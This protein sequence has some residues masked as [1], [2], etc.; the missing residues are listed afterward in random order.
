MDPPALDKNGGMTKFSARSGAIIFAPP[1]QVSSLAESEDSYGVG[2][3]TFKRANTS[4]KT[5]PLMQDFQR[6]VEHMK[7]S[8]TR[9]K[10]AKA[11]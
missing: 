6:H 11:D 2:S 10:S 7:R 4:P 8:A 1:F 9:D 3:N 5:A